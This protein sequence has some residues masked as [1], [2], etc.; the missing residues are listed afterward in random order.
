M[1]H[2]GYLPGRKQV[3]LYRIADA[4]IRVL[5]WF[6]AEDLAAEAMRIIDGLTGV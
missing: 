4:E 5:A 2:I 1:I 6:K 3:A